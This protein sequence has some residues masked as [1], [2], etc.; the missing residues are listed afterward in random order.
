MGRKVV[1]SIVA[2]VS[3]LNAAGYKV[4]E[5]SLDSISLAASNVAASF[6]PDAAYY[7]PANMMFLDESR[8]YFEN[9]LAW[10][11]I[12][13]VKFKLNDGREFESQ[14]FDSMASTFHFVSPEY[15]QNWRFGLSLA[16]PAGIGIGWTD[17]DA[18]FT[19]RRFK[20]KVIELNPSVAYR[21]TDSFAI[22]VGARAVYTK[23]RVVTEL[24]GNG[25][26]EL[27]GDSIDYGYNLAMTYKPTQDWTLA[28]TY[29]SKV[30][31]T[32]DGDANIDAKYPH[33]LGATIPLSYKG[34]VNVTIP[35]PA[36]LVLA[37]SY[38]IK[39]TTLMFAYERTFWS[40]FTGYDFEY[41]ERTASTNPVVNT[42]FGRLYD[43][44][45][46]KKYRDTNTFRIGVAHD[47]SDKLRVMAGFAY[48]Q[49]AAK[50]PSSVSFDLPDTKS[51]A[52]S[53]GLNYKATENL[54]LTLGGLYQDRQEQK[55]QMKAIP[56]DVHGEFSKAKIWIVGTG[57]KY[58]F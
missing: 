13:P 20:L 56:N 17:A 46:E 53:L 41:P 30:N 3:L 14:K 40:K 55:A 26:R 15:Y 51:Y 1:L 49:K 23:G 28:A 21:V 9:N 52:Y 5:Q 48:D 31:L 7:N 24:Y 39:D 42:I 43:N 22:G 54:E 27:E 6:G 47:V 33:P 29:R 2:C 25:Q 11:H 37:T 36:Q 34:G 35:L 38:K 18:A 45:V 50:E 10:F 16:V 8:H 57:L 19:G 58:K 4:P 12:D 32:L 44:K